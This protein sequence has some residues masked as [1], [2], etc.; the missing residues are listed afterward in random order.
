MLF[1]WHSLGNRGLTLISNF[2]SDLNLTD[3]HTCY[4]MFRAD[5]LKKI[6][7]EE[8]R[9]AFDPE[10]T[11]KI[12]KLRLRVYEVPISYHNRTYAEGKKIGVKDL[13][14]AIYANLKYNLRP[15]R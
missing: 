4:K 14:R 8:D 12:S 15:G 6:T 1:Y 13:F 7:L 11:A 10:I 2:L 5:V 9:F 3:V